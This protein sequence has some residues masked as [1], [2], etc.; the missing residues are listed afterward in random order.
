MAQFFVGQAWAF[1]MKPDIKLLLDQAKQPRQHY[2]PA[3]AGWNGPEEKASDAAPN[4]TYDQLRR[5]A[6]PAELKQQLIAAAIPDWRIVLALMVMILGLRTMMR[7]RGE[8]R[9]LLNVI[10]FPVAPVNVRQA[11]DAA[12]AA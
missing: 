2:V 10:G 6:T 5:E 12:E 11:T 7:P 9:P 1:P 3:R 4:A 8:K